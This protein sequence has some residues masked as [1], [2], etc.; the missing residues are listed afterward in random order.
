MSRKNVGVS[1]VDIARKPTIWS[2]IELAAIKAVYCFFAGLLVS[3]VCFSAVLS[4]VVTLALVLSPIW[5][6][7][8]MLA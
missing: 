6:T 4:L 7:V 1:D 8:W 5:A 3:L 2:R